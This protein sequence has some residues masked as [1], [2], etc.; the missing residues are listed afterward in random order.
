MQKSFVASYNGLI[1]M[2]KAKIAL[3]GAA[4]IAATL[5]LRSCQTKD[6]PQGKINVPSYDKGEAP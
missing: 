3:V 5:G 6:V 2:G 1:T 4:V